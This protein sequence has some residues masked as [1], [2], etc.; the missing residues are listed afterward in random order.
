MSGQD[1]LCSLARGGGWEASG[2]CLVSVQ[3]GPPAGWP[4]GEATRLARRNFQSPQP[5]LSG[6]PWETPGWPAAS[7]SPLS[8]FLSKRSL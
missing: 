5:P 8:A 4:L 7:R 3:N 6:D 2:L 1:L